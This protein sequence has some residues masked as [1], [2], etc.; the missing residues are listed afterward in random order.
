MITTKM[1]KEHSD[2]CN[3]N[4]KKARKGPWSLEPHRSN[5]E[6]K[7]LACMIV[8][9]PRGGNLCG[10][11]G[12]KEGHTLYGVRYE[13]LDNVRVHGG[14]TYSDVCSDYI[15]HQ[16]DD[17][18]TWWFGFDCAHSQDVMPNYPS[19]IDFPGCTYKDI[20]YVKK[21]TQELAEQLAG[22]GK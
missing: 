17:G 12:V 18:E 6:H 16:N 22:Y 10:Y 14:L 20:E 5:W 9:N 13:A 3:K 2:L 19:E 11:V 4:S 1:I 7:G 15:C 21:E 8:R